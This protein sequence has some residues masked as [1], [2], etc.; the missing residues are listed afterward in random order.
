MWI[1]GTS[2]RLVIYR[3]TNYNQNL[4]MVSDLHIIINIEKR[5]ERQERIP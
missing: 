1:V 4:K 2:Y 3:L 5:P